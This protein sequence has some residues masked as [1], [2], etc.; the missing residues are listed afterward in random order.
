[1]SLN[2]WDINSFPYNIKK[3]YDLIV[4]TRVAY[5]C[6]QPDIMMG[7]FKNILNKGGHILIDWGLGDHWRFKNY[8]VGWVKNNEHEYAYN[9]NNFLWST[10]WHDEFLN[11]EQ[12]KKYFEL[13]KKFGYNNIKPKE[14]IQKEV[15]S[16]LSLNDLMEDFE[17]KCDIM[18][19]WE[20]LPQIYFIILARK[21]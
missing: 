5:F 11:N 4:C 7:E 10:V 13:I 20:D 9:E 2:N 14:I 15:T 12:F 17:I 19:L 8:K 18:T 21:K 3:K 16:I 1:L 6:K